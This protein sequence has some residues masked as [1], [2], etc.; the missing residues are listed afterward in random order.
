MTTK[1]VFAYASEGCYA[2]RVLKPR[3]ME[4]MEK[5]GFTNIE[6]LDVTEDTNYDRATE[7]NIKGIPTVIFFDDITEVGREVGNLPDEEY[8]KYF[9]G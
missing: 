7:L 9:K 8:L 1:I 5:K 2:C 3:F 4:L 6:W